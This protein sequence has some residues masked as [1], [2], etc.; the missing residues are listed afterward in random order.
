[1][2]SGYLWCMGERKVTFQS[3]AVRLSRSI[4]PL[5]FYSA[6]YAAFVY[7]YTGVAP[8]NP[9]LTPVFYHLWFFYAFTVVTALLLVMKPANA[10]PVVG[11]TITGAALILC[12]GGMSTFGAGHAF[13]NLSGSGLYLVYAFA[14]FYAGNV[15]SSG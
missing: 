1:M 13:E 9:L 5:V 11:A 3:A 15:R 8:Q 10:S 7:F 12:G 4:V 14:G 2:L 6:I